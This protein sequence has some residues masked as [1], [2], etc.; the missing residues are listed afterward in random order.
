M[1]KQEISTAGFVL[2]LIGG[3]F[4]LGVAGAMG[5]ITAPFG[6][7]ELVGWMIWAGIISGIA[8]IAGSILIYSGQ[9][10]LGG[11]LV[12]AFSLIGLAGTGGFLIGTILGV[13]GGV[14]ALVKKR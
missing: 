1:K 9:K 10:V 14:L 13:I 7:F 12:I 4:I 11:A 5:A 2:S 8:V 3:L 6:G